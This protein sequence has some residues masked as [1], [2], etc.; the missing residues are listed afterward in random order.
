[1]NDKSSNQSDVVSLSAE[2]LAAP[3]AYIVVDNNLTLI[4]VNHKAENLDIR[5]GSSVNDYFDEKSKASFL[6]LIDTSNNGVFEGPCNQKGIFEFHVLQLPDVAR[7]ALWLFD[8][9]EIRLVQSQLQKLKKPERKFLHQI[10][11]LVST[12]LGYAELVEL[13]LEENVILNGDRLAAIRRYQN[14]I[15][16]GLRQSEN[17]IQ[18][19]KRGAMPYFDNITQTTQHVLVV[20]NEPTRVE[21]LV[22]LLQSQQYKVTSFVDTEAATKFASLNAKSL[23]L[24]VL[25]AADQLAEYLL[26]ANANLQI[27]VCTSDHQGFE[28]NRLHTIADTPLDINELLRTVLEMRSGSL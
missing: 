16:T 15:G 10:G 7:T 23:N 14:E 28:D 2:I 27:L 21:L 11:N 13:M 1:M 18:H 24:A 6:Q 8:V 3:V 9:S 17:M 12:T 5:V 4:G 19:E 26:E 22:E 20:H 25:G